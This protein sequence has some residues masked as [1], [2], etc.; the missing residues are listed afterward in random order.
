MPIKHALFVT[1]IAVAALAGCKK[2]DDTTTPAPADPS[3]AP[4]AASAPAP[5]PPNGTLAPA[6]TDNTP[7]TDNA[8]SKIAPQG[9][10]SSGS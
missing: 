6:P 7:T 2:A 10:A 4:P 1:V 9:N 8:A 5:A 3:A